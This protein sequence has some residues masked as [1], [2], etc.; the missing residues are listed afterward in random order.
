MYRSSL[1]YAGLRFLAF[2]ATL[3][4]LIGCSPKLELRALEPLATTHTMAFQITGTGCRGVDALLHGRS[5]VGCTPG[6]VVVNQ[7]QAERLAHTLKSFEGAPLT[8]RLWAGLNGQ[9]AGTTA[10]WMLG[11]GLIKSAVE[12][13]QRPG[14][15]AIADWETQ[16]SVISEQLLPAEAVIHASQWESFLLLQE[17]AWN[18]SKEALAQNWMQREQLLQANEPWNER[19]LQAVMAQMTLDEMAQPLDALWRDSNNTLQQLKHFKP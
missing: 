6:P 8:E 9:Y 10:N 11:L 15:A 16:W 7:E 12:T 1:R 18:Q 4:A 13:P 2:V 3:G 17:G 14:D 19:S 5:P